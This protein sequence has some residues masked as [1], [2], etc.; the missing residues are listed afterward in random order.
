[1]Y[2]LSGETKVDGAVNTALDTVHTMVADTW[3]KL[4][5]RYFSNPKKL[6]YYVD[7]A[8][9]ATVL[10]EDLDADAFPDGVVP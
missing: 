4:G 6:C 3:V 9:V 1:M 10:V 2:Q 8:V 7:G 5:F